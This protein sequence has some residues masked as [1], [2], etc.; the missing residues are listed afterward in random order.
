MTQDD[1]YFKVASCINTYFLSDIL[2]QFRTC[3]RDERGMLVTNPRKVFS[4]YVHGWLPFDVFAGIPWEWLYVDP[5]ATTTHRMAKLRFVRVFRFLRCF[6]VV[7]VTRMVSFSSRLQACIESTM[8]RKYAGLLYLLC[9]GFTLVHW[10]ACLWYFCGSANTGRTTWLDT[11]LDNAYFG[12]ALTDYFYR[13]LV[14]VYFVLT[15]MTTVGF[16]DVTPTNLEEVGFAICLLFISCFVFAWLTGHIINTIATLNSHSQLMSDRKLALLRYLNWR[17]VPKKLRVSIEQYLVFLWETNR[18]HDALEES[19][20]NELPPVLRTELC[21]WIHGRILR[22]APFL[23]W[24]HGYSACT[25]MLAGKVMTS[26]LER[27]DFVFHLS[28]RN[29]EIYIL[30]SGIVCLSKNEAVL[31]DEGEMDRSPSAKSE[32]LD[33]NFVIP[34]LQSS[35][36]SSVARQVFRWARTKREASKK[37]LNKEG[38]LNYWQHMGEM[39]ELRCQTQVDESNETLFSTRVFSNA[40]TCLRRQDIRM[41][42]AARVLQRR[43][44]AKSAGNAAG[45]EPSTTSGTSASRSSSVVE[46]PAYFGESCLWVPFE[47]WGEVAPLYS[48]SATCRTRAEVLCI[49][50]P[51]VQEIIIRF[52]PWLGDR[53]DCFR[54]AVVDGLQLQAAVPGR[55]SSNLGNPECSDASIASVPDAKV[56]TTPESPKSTVLPVSL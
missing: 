12:E 45:R 9:L 19:I 40:A 27:G 53:F 44:R 5:S 14:S 35:N 11:Y 41:R 21:D 24:M 13:Y 50:R 37:H 29:D 16:G 46:A 56:A 26:I 18:G 43:W 32:S 47:Q 1:I 30:V 2:L 33:A 10:L 39:R 4:H 55:V 22:N 7:R 3:Y 6:R 48:Y 54:Q 38:I 15:T 8:V 17:G 31:E 23:A 34:R 36:F 42:V 28:Q 25:K 51:A 20:K 52:S 49:P